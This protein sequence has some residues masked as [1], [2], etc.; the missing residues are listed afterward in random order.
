MANQTH[1][2][3]GLDP[4]DQVHKVGGT[5]SEYPPAWGSA[6][7]RIFWLTLAL[8]FLCLVAL[9]LWLLVRT[10]ASA[11]GQGNRSGEPSVT[12]E[13]PAHA[14]ATSPEAMA[15]EAVDPDAVCVA[16]GSATETEDSDSDGDGNIVYYRRRNDR[17]EIALS[18][19]DGPHPRYTPEILSI[20]AEYGIN[21]TFFM[22]GENVIYYP[23]VAAAVIAAGHEVGNHSFSHRRLSGLSEWEIRSEITRCEE[24]LANV[25]ECRPHLLRPPEGSMSATLR[26]LSGQ[27]D[28]RLVLWDID[29]RDWAH[30]P[31]TVICQ[32]ILDKVQ[33]GDIILMH[34]Y[35]GR[36]SPT[37]EA[38][39]LVIP[40]LLQR[41]YH[42]V[43]VSELIDGA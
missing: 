12:E 34:D 23:E 9:A 18:F 36:D 31:P 16:A 7:G 40:E 35:I 4:T 3:N 5:P 20:L 19:D 21:A 27:M 6:G 26:R 43:T 24:A 2:Q 32:Q 29:T 42:F 10:P 37:P 13:L 11:G 15:G 38:L 1:K 30:T 14:D 41:G 39:R 33:A 22:V 25:G 28:Y 8:F 17:M